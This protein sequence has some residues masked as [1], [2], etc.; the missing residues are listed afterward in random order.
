MESSL[1]SLEIDY[2]KNIIL[3]KKK[4]VIFTHYFWLINIF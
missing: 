4:K 3:F 1:I 2:D